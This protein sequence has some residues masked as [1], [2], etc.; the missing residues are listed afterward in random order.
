M[1]R[2]PGNKVKA[3]RRETRK[4]WR[5]RLGERWGEVGTWWDSHRWNPHRLRHNAGTRLRKEY[6][7]EAA[8]VILGH[9]TLSVTQI[10]AEKNVEAAM[11]IMGEVG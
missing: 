5:A 9:R 2:V 3:L 1:K 4:E 11:R 10:Y 8:Q 6:G 7:L